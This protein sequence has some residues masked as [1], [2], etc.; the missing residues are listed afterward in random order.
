[1]TN[2]PMAAAV[3]ALVVTTAG[4]A[5]L[6]ESEQRMMTGTMAGTAG[7]AAIGALAGNAALGAGIGAATGL[8][9][10]FIYDQH[11]QAE[12]RAFQQGVSAGQAGG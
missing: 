12:Q 4:C 7:G 6:S 3:L 8:A 1:M 10:G 11:K 9:G 5:G 2:G